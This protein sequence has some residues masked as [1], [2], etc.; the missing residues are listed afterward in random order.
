MWQKR[1]IYR[2]QTECTKARWWSSSWVSEVF[3]TCWHWRRSP[4][5]PGGPNPK[6]LSGKWPKRW[7]S[8]KRRAPTEVVATLDENCN[9]CTW[10]WAGCKLDTSERLCSLA[11][12]K[13]RSRSRWP[14]K[15]PDKTLRLWSKLKNQNYSSKQSG[16][17]SFREFFHTY[18]ICR[19]RSRGE[20]GKC[21]CS[22]QIPKRPKA[23]CVE[24]P[25]R[26]CDYFLYEHK[27]FPPLLRRRGC[28]HF[29]RFLLAHYW[30]FWHLW[31][32]TC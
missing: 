20:L 25:P 9:P 7:L 11:W 2:R 3:S 19:R 27:S 24:R 15:M 8:S 6:R 23:K 5:C 26:W 16:Y 29:H 4:E 31:L 18:L 22:T 12:L 13:V 21:T 32:P 28:D 30:R 10:L 14:W 17:F 1:K